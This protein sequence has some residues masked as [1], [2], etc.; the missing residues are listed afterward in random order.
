[1]ASGQMH[2]LHD[3]VTMMRQPAELPADWALVQGLRYTRSTLQSLLGPGRSQLEGCVRRIL[4]LKKQCELQAGSRRD[5]GG[6]GA[7]SGLDR[8]GI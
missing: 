6:I 4:E 3:E 1:M 5:W 7:G 8:D 2:W